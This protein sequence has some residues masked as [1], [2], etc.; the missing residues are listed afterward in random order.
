MEEMERP[1]P[2]PTGIIDDSSW[3]DIDSRQKRKREE[4]RGVWASS[5]STLSL[6]LCSDSFGAPRGTRTGERGRE[7]GILLGMKTDGT[8]VC[9]KVTG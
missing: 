7:V 6:L 1:R 2:A 9:P 3:T 5:A 8:S 4:P